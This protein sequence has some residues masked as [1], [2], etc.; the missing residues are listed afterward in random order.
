[1]DNKLT[2]KNWRS[3]FRT[4]N[5]IQKPWFLKAEWLFH[6]ATIILE[7]AIEARNYIGKGNSPK[8]TIKKGEPY[9]ETILDYSSMQQALLLIGFSIENLLKGLWIKKHNPDDK[10][11]NNDKINSKIITHKLSELANEIGIE[12]SQEEINTLNVFRE[13]IEWK[14]RY[15]IPLN[16]TDYVNSN[17]EGYSKLLSGFTKTEMPKELNS[18]L[19]KISNHK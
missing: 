3:S 5:S 1:L 17:H 16:V 10:I 12:F 7:K 15:P 18:I 4:V 14:G 11:I 19:E 2:Y 8:G 6:S 9:Y 13:L